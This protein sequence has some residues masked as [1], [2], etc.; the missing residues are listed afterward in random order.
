MLSI[1]QSLGGVITPDGEC[2]WNE[3]QIQEVVEFARS[4]CYIILGGD[5]LTEQLTYS[6]DNWFYSPKRDNSFQ[7]FS[8]KSVLESYRKAKDYISSYTKTHTVHVFFTLVCVDTLTG[9]I[10]AY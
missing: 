7:R 8:E 9:F 5:V 1:P 6:G 10:Q 4:K 2:A 3:S